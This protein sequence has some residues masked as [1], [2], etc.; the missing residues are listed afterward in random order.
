MSLTWDNAISPCGN[1]GK[2]SQNSYLARIHLSFSSLQEH[3]A[4]AEYNQFSYRQTKQ[5]W[6]KLSK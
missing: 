6:T 2:N 4:M 3:T 1:G 5:C